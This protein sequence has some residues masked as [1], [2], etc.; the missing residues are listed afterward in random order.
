MP[1]TFTREDAEKH[2]AV[3]FTI[4][5]R[6]LYAN[7]APS[8]EM[9]NYVLVPDRFGVVRM[10]TGAVIG[11]VGGQY[12][13]HQN[14]ILF[15]F[16]DL[17]AKESGGSAR[18]EAVMSL[19]E[20]RTVGA[21]MHLKDSGYTIPNSTVDGR[22]D[23]TNAYALFT[24]SHDGKLATQG[25][26][27]S[28]RVVC[29]NTLNWAIGGNA[30][31]IKIRHS[32]DTD[33]KVAEAVKTLETFAET[34]KHAQ[35]IAYEMS[36]SAPTPDAIKTIIETLMPTPED[37][38]SGS[39]KTRYET[40]IGLLTQGIQAEVKLLP[41]ANE[42]SYFTLMNGFTRYSDWLAPVQARGRDEG[43]AALESA[44]MPNGHGATFKAKAEAVIIASMRDNA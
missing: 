34:G 9:P 10:D 4:E 42:A 19:R 32:G 26:F 1:E 38:A 43:K 6:Q 39:A 37:D 21:L 41:A 7:L 12:A 24:T 8:G 5:K 20:G 36:A 30:S 3:G 27:T 17:L 28:V 16:C 40:R 22:P 14:S 2:G 31:A 13:L 11:D 33:R 15:D 35:E 44:L 25:M 29:W 18:Y 23:V